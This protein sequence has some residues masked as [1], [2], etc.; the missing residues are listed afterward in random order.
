MNEEQ[1]MA[2]VNELKDG[3]YGGARFFKESV[4]GCVSRVRHDCLDILHFYK[5]NLAIVDFM[6]LKIS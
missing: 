1:K 5:S 4:R 6:I 3:G 2:E